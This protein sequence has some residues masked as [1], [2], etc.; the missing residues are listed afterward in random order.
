M[1]LA[2]RL[3]GV[4]PEVIN[5][6]PEIGADRRT[7]RIIKIKGERIAALTEIARIIGLHSDPLAEAVQGVGERL[8]EAFER[9][10]RAE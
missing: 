2:I 9:A 10:A 5:R 4:P 7:G 3:E 8:K 1:A 6:I